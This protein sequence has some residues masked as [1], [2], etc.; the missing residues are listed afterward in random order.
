MEED[1]EKSDDSSDHHGSVEDCKSSTE[2]EYEPDIWG[3][4]Y[5]SINSGQCVPDRFLVLTLFLLYEAQRRVTG[6]GMR[7]LTRPQLRQSREE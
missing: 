2:V 7:Y 5:R 3:T 6:W 1:E 4:P